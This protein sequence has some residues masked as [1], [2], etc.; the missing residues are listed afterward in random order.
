M[1][2]NGSGIN[3]TSKER[4]FDSQKLFNG[5]NWWFY[6][7]MTPSQNLRLSVKTIIFRHLFRE[8]VFTAKNFVKI[9][10]KFCA[11][12]Q[13]EK[14]S[15][16]SRL[17]QQWTKNLKSPWNYLNESLIIFLMYILIFDEKFGRGNTTQ[18]EY[19]PKL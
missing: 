12:E 17:D 8:K 19:N 11:W 2:K 18:G 9:L 6:S 13:V 10:N 4:T 16:R 1:N 14:F 15:F 5:A 7:D 3:R